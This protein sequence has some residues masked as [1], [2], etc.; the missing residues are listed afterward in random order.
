[1][2]VDDA[3]ASGFGDVRVVAAVALD[4]IAIGIGK[5]VTNKSGGILDTAKMREEEVDGIGA[6][7]GWTREVDDVEFSGSLAVM[8]IVPGDRIRSG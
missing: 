5:A 4:V 8:E 2:E 1:M 3:L 6:K 7:G